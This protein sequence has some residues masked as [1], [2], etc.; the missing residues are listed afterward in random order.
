MPAY[1]KKI[2]LP[3]FRGYRH[4]SVSLHGIHMEQRLRIPLFDDPP[5]LFHRLHCADLVI[6]L[7]DR[8][9]DGIV[10]ERFF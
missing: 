10:P 4:F 3:F 5:R 2:D 6:D 9:E 8:N 7:H 1:G